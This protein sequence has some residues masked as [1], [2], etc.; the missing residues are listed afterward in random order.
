MSNDDGKDPKEQARPSGS[1]WLRRIIGGLHRRPPPPMPP[2]NRSGTGADSVK[3]YLE[4][5]RS[6]RPAPL[7]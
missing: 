2:G 6:S 7:E 5:D 1:E 3:P 4:Q